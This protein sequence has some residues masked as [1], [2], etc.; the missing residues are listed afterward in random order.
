[1]LEQSRPPSE[2]IVVDS[3]DVHEP[4]AELIK[5]QTAGH[6][7]RVHIVQSKCG[8]TLQRNIGLG[9][10]TE[11]LVFFPDDDSIWYPG[12]ASEIL[13]VYE[14]DSEHLIA[15][16]CA[17]EAKSPPSNFDTGHA[18]YKMTVRDRINQ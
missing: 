11:P 14:N 13:E 17:A 7:I 15:A 6:P 3:S 16:V 4:V 2:L 9:L 5:Q 12:V 18:S 10:V 8:L 1:M